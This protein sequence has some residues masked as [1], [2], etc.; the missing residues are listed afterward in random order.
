M[1]LK[2]ITVPIGVLLVIFESRPDCLPQVCMRN[3]LCLVYYI[4]NN[5]NTNVLFLANLP[6]QITRVTV[7]VFWKLLSQVNAHLY[8][9]R[10]QEWS[11]A[12]CP[13]SLR[14]QFTWD[15]YMTRAFFFLIVW[16]LALF[17]LQNHCSSTI[18]V[19]ID[20]ID[21]FVSY[22]KSKCSNVYSVF[23]LRFSKF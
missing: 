9:R 11:P 6:Q 22:K 3:P 8:P 7:S 12:V 20:F 18:W 1:T 23:E 17:C 16:Q 21:L 5:A 2:K 15:C 19:T 14:N 10:I 4:C 13:P